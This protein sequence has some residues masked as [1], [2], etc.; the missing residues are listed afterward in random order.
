MLVLYDYNSNAIH[1]ELMKSK[2]GTKILAAYQRA[3]SLFTQQG[4][5]P[6]IQRLDNKASTALQSFMTANQV[7]FQ[8]APP[9]LHRR[10]AAERA[11]RTFKN[12]FIAGLCSTNP[13]FPLHLW[14]C[15]IPHAILTLNLLQGSRINPT[16]SAHTQLHGAFDYN[17]TPLAPPGTRVLV[18]EKP[19]VRETWAPHA[20][21][22]WYLGPA[23]NH[24]RCHCV[25]ITEMR[26]KRVAN[27]LAWFPSKIPVPTASSTDRALAA[28]RDLVC[29]LQNPSP[30][31]PFTPLDAN[32]HQARTQLTELFALVAAPASSAAAPARVPPVP[33][34]VPRLPLLRSALP[35]QL[36]WPSMPLPF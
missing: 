9:H 14:D 36:S 18:H 34:P 7:D 26:A 2:S 32:Q 15:H 4:L 1:V 12:H 23:M 29:A 11:I 8:L 19:A 21:E 33:P 35:F 28:A 27:M 3:H 16:L 17:C 24:Y 25:W 13:D 5:Q 10:N 20:V 31:L 22:G 6:Q 30:A